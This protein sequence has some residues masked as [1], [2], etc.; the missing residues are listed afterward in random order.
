VRYTP[1]G[2]ERT[3]LGDS[4]TDFDF[5]SQRN[6]ASFGLM[7]YNARYY[8]P[9]LGRFISPDTIVPEPTSS[10]GTIAIAILEIIFSN[11]LIQPGI[12]FVVALLGVPHPT[13]KPLVVVH[14]TN[15]RTPVLRMPRVSLLVGYMLEL[16]LLVQI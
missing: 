13:D 5:T 15:R 4:P 3:G 7:D 14:H 8:S 11:I 12:L 9:I 1:Y 10:G 16:W 6:E 2:R